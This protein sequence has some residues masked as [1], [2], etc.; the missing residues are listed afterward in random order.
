[1]II[2]I[3]FQM[4]N[5]KHQKLYTKNIE[6][7]IIVIIVNQKMNINMKNENV[8]PNANHVIVENLTNRRTAHIVIVKVRADVVVNQKKHVVVRKNVLIN[9]W[10]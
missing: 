7:V 6:N 2:Q 5:L 1:M 3:P 8:N 9:M 4:T 10:L